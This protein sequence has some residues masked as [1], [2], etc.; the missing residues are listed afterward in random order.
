MSLGGALNAAVSGL[1]AQSQAIAVVSENIA[2]VSTTAYKSNEITFESLISGDTITGGVTFSTGQ[3]LTQQG[4]IENTSVSTNVAISGSGFFVVTDDPDALASS[5]TY[6][7]NGDFA[8][9]ESGL[10]INNEGVILL[11]YPTDAEGN[12]LAASTDDLNALGAVDLN[13]VS[14]TAESTTEIGMSLNLPADAQVADDFTTTVEIFDQLGVSHTMEVTYTKTAVNTWTADYTDPYQTSLGAI[15]PA[16]AVVAPASQTITFDGGGAINLID[17]VPAAEFAMTFTG[18]TATTGS[19][20]L[21]VNV[22]VGEQG[23]F[24]G[25]TQFSSDNGDADITIN[26]IEQDGVRFGQLTGVEIQED[27]L[28]IAVFDNGV[29][30][31]IFQIPIA[32][33][34]NPNALVNI[35][36]SIYDESE[37]AGNLNLRLPGQGAAGTLIAEAIELST[38][39]TSTEFNKMIVAQQAYSSA[40]QVVSTVDDMFETLI[41]AVR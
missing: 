15:S 38:V 39:D 25:L 32:T 18:F 28:V 1:N 24:S 37:E 26:S 41:G 12:V 11:G 10:L 21:S 3:R 9:D 6:T 2:N 8:T 16:T 17:G 34:S 13:A 20:D 23:L 19:N 5:Y 4:T 36:G 30:Q 29:R 35:S 33:F 7:R 31:A 22:D 14:S 40:A 27:G